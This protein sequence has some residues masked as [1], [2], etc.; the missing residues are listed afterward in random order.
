MEKL[1][2]E[3][4][5]GFRL[6]ALYFSP[7]GRNNGTVVISSATGVKKE[8]YI[9]FSRSLCLR[10]YSVLLFDYRGIG[11]SEHGQ[12]KTLNSF[13]HEWGTKD[14]NA[15]MDHLVNKLGLTDIIWM[16]HSV[17]A[18]LTGFIKPELQKHIR[19][20]IAI[21]AAFGYWRYFPRPMNYF[22]WFL[23][24]AVGPALVKLYGYGNMKRIGWGENLPK[25]MMLEWRHWC[26]N[27]TYFT[28][29]LM[30]VLERDKFYGFK[31]PITA[32][33]A[34]DDFIANDK[35]VQFM[36]S[37]F[38]D[39]PY[40]INKIMVNEHTPLKAGHT[41]IFRKKFKRTLWP[42]LYRLVEGKTMY[43]RSQ[44]VLSSQAHARLVGK[45][46]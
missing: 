4:E 20:I 6:S 30:K 37:F 12:L 1:F 44:F 39:A 2:I 42:L 16:G 8:F 17:G 5:D 21:N 23:W 38:P 18:Q 27:K 34:S 19:S 28:S 24:Y 11:E 35:S 10:G 46:L 45:A 31:I 36:Q 7:V 33:Y 29:A 3:A 25:N 32:V 41:G 22:I 14:M 43:D 9:N 40:A 26:L 15:V 13:M